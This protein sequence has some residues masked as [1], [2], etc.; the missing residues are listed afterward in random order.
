MQTVRL[1]FDLTQG[2]KCLTLTENREQVTPQV[3]ATPKPGGQKVPGHR[4][5]T[6]A[7][8]KERNPPAAKGGDAAPAEEAAQ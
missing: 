3:T 6:T 2:P 4:P 5:D 7:E 8:G 1:R